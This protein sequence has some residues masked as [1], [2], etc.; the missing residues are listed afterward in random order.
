M[1]AP[2]STIIIDKVSF[3]PIMV[4]GRRDSEV[5]E[6]GMKMWKLLGSQIIEAAFRRK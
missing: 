6:L 1:R 5:E 2:A 3:A 4:Y